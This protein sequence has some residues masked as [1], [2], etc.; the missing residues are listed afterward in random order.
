MSLANEP[1][2]YEYKTAF[3]LS[4]L[5]HVEQLSWDVVQALVAIANNPDKLWPIITLLA[6][7]RFNLSNRI[8]SMRTIMDVIV[9]SHSHP[10]ERCPEFL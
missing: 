10:L 3:F 6:E 8:A 2:R 5:V 7:E 1:N 9:K 4:A